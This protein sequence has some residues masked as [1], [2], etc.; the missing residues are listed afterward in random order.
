MIRGLERRLVQVHGSPR[1]MKM[2]Q[3]VIE[4]C[5]QFLRGSRRGATSESI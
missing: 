5:L 3:V 2:P 1:L 4:M